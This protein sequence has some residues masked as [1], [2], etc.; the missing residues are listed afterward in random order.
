MK[1]SIFSLFIFFIVPTLASAQ[2]LFEMSGT[3]KI[4]YEVSS[5]R[6]D[7]NAKSFCIQQGARNATLMGEYRYDYSEGTIECDVHG[8][9]R[10]RTIFF[11]SGTYQCSDQQLPTF[12]LEGNKCTPPEKPCRTSWDSI[13]YCTIKCEN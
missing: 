4:S 9:C 11:A 13:P 2:G 5:Q 8:V 12:D 3:S 10:R 7:K 6:A 1:P